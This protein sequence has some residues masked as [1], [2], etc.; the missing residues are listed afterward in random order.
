MEFPGEDPMGKGPVLSL[1]QQGFNPWPK[2]FCI[3]WAHPRPKKRSIKENKTLCPSSV[4][5][6]H[7]GKNTDH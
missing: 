5:T 3:Q 1:L 6:I 7:V 4:V 2:D